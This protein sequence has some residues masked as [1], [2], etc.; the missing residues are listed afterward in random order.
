MPGKGPAKERR[1]YGTG[2]VFYRADRG[3]WVAQVLGADGKAITRSAK[4]EP[5]AH[6]LL[7]RL[8]VDKESNKLQKQSRET[9]AQYLAR[10]LSDT[11]KISNAPTTYSRYASHIR[12]H[13]N[14]Y[15]GKKKLTELTPAD[16][17]VMQRSLRLSPS[18]VRLIRATLHVALEQAFR[19]GEIPSNPVTVVRGPRVP[20]LERPVLGASKLPTLLAAIRR[21]RHRAIFLLEL[22]TGLRINEV[23]GLTW[24]DVDWDTGKLYLRHQLTRFP[25]R[26]ELREFKSQ[27]RGDALLP[28]VL[29]EE[30]R[31]CRA[32]QA[33][34]REQAGEWGNDWDLVFTSPDGRPL[35][36]T[37]VYRDFQLL[38]KGAGL[39]HLRL[40]DLRHQAASQ[41]N[42]AGVDTRTIS[43]VLGHADLGITLDYIHSIPEDR[44]RA[45]DV[46]DEIL[47]RGNPASVFGNIAVS[48]TDHSERAN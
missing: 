42:A 33:A 20:K 5:A 32:Q 3:R 12:L 25:G 15:I 30:L 4:T 36:A 7:A 29:L 18:T 13:I 6:K 23:L 24:P 41:L 1:P 19:D 14:P 43:S 44:T 47:R 34:Q 27:N 40:H 2:S 10:W 28:A 8:L 35:Y 11:V 17:R 48:I 16:I 37:A 21:H 38:L 22:G 46:M 31:T 26:W 39:P 45:A 9:V